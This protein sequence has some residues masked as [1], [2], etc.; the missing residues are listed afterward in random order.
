MTN[1][2]IKALPNCCVVHQDDFFKVSQYTAP[3]RTRRSSHEML[4][5]IVCQQTANWPIGVICLN[6]HCHYSWQPS[7][8]ADCLLDSERKG[9]A[10]PLKVNSQ[11]S[12]IH[13]FVTSLPTRLTSY[14]CFRYIN[15]A[16]IVIHRDCLHGLGLLYLSSI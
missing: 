2:L 14:Y 3:V 6:E 4:K 10:S 15:F 11:K 8:T 7:N 5:L 12:H 13:L 1:R 9:S 16:L